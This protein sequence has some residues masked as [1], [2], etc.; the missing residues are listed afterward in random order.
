MS[1]EWYME[2]PELELGSC[3]LASEARPMPRC[4][5]TPCRKAFGAQADNACVGDAG[6]SF[7]P[8]REAQCRWLPSA[9]GRGLKQQD[10]C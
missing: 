2:T 9:D 4:C 7:A 10:N 6:G 8:H 3:M 5:C 1:D